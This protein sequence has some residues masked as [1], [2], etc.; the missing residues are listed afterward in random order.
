MPQGYREMLVLSIPLILSTASWS[1]Q[2]FVDR[3]FLSWYSQDA[4]AASMPAGILNFAIICAFIGTAG[5]AGTFIAQYV[6]AKRENRVGTVIVHSFYISLAGALFLIALAPFSD[7][8]FAF[9]GHDPVVA[10]QESIY[11]RILCYGGIAP[12]LSSAFAGFYTGQGKNWPVM[13]IN[14]AT[15][16][17]NLVLDYFMIFGIGPFPEMGIAGAAWATVIAGYSSLAI[18]L[19]L[20]LTGRGRIRFGFTKAALWDRSFMIRFL[21]FGVPSGIHFFLEIMGF[22]IFLLLLGRIGVQELA[23]TNIAFNINSLAFMPIVGLGMAV[24]M[25]VGRYIGE[26]A[27]DKAERATNSATELAIIWNGILGALYVLFPLVFIEFFRSPDA[28]FAGT[29]AVGVILLRFVALYSILDGINIVYA[30]AIK[31]A[32]DTRFVMINGLLL[33]LGVLVIP[34]LMYIELFRGGIYGSWGIITFYIMLLG[35]IHY[36]RFR[37]GK[38]RSMQVIEL[39]EGVPSN[40][41][42]DPT[43]MM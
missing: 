11:F 2:Q 4:L 36:L 39:R 30:S 28:S 6:G 24:T 37:S 19:V 42:A 33:S 22:T 18:Y 21:K 17:I 10:K 16:V 13:W 12:I 1:I 26:G 15:T 5:Y 38:W 41:P 25:V 31:G 9:I 35:V 40:H 3:M 8:L 29:A 32:G 7:Q 34:T 14:V 27:P 43:A 23:A 20:M